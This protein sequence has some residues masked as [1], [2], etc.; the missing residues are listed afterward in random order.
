MLLYNIFIKDFLLLTLH[1]IH[2][3]LGRFEGW[4]VVG[5][6]GDSHVLADVACGLGSTVL[7]NEAAE[8]T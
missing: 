6:N 1:L 2:E 7:D 8:S 4:N 3:D 5:G